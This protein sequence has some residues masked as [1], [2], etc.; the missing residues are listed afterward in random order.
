MSSNTNNQNHKYHFVPANLEINRLNAV[1]TGRP[2]AEIITH[3]VLNFYTLIVKKLIN[4]IVFDDGRSKSKGK[5]VFINRSERRTL[6]GE[7]YHEIIKSLVAANY[8]E[9][10]EKWKYNKSGIGNHTKK[11][12]LPKWMLK[13][14]KMFKQVKISNQRVI[15]NMIAN[16]NRLRYKKSNQD[17]W[18]E[19]MIRSSYRIMLHDT[20]ACR[21]A[22]QKHL[23]KVNSSNRRFKL[24]LSASDVVEIFNNSALDQANIDLFGKRVHTKITNMPKKIRKFLYFDNRIGEKLKC[25]DIVNSQPVFMSIAT[26]AILQQFTPELVEAA[27]IVSKYQNH[28][29]VLNFQKECAD[30]TI[31]ETIIE[32]FSA[33]GIQITRDQAKPVAYTGFFGNYLPYELGKLKS[34]HKKLA[35]Q[36]LKEE[37][38]GMYKMFREM[39]MGMWA[40]NVSSK[41]DYANNCMLAQRLESQIFYTVIVPAVWNA[42]YRDF[43]TIHD[44]IICCDSDCAGIKAVM[45]A[46]FQRLNIS[47]KLSVS[48]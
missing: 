41:K 13:G 7:D 3:K 20:D 38:N 14:D 47:L 23:D 12:A 21:K 1:L 34:E 4:N 29:D 22:V 40:E 39:K 36:F 19:E 9:S 31:Y 37:Y 43:S 28:L 45:M 10:D 35:Y 16:F 8:L 42:G 26:P 24:K 18:R 2:G 48:C 5:W 6:L 27:P 32:Y 33:K 25:V 46:E 30:G 44:S 11:Y 15:Q 17:V